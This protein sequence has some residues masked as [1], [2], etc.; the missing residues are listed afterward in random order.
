MIQSLLSWNNCKL[1]ALP[2]STFTIQML[3]FGI[4]TLCS[5][6]W[7][8]SVYRE[9]VVR[10]SVSAWQQWALGSRRLL[11]SL[12][13]CIQAPAPG[14]HPSLANTGPGWIK[15]CGYSR[16]YRAG[17]HH[18]RE[19]WGQARTRTEVTSNQEPVSV[20]CHY[21][22]CSKNHAFFSFWFDENLWLSIHC[23]QSTISCRKIFSINSESPVSIEFS[24]IYNWNQL[25]GSDGFHVF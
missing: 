23:Y 20:S 17:P 24:S 10:K 4:Q 9:S 19:P 5:G 8:Y 7:M 1:S 25:A 14:G 18:H 21:V 13:N 15:L 16:R 22:S 2:H 11:I 3:Y 12:Y 6:C